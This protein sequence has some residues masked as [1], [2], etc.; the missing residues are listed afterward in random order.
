[1]SNCSLNN[2][3]LDQIGI[4]SLLA[5]EIRSWFLKILDVN[6]PVLKILNGASIGELI[7]IAIDTQAR[8][9]VIYASSDTTSPPMLASKSFILPAIGTSPL[10]N[11]SELE[12]FE[13]PTEESKRD[14]E[15]FKKSANLPA[16]S[17]PLPKVPVLHRS[18]KLSFSQAMFWFVMLF[19]EDKTGL[20]HT[21]CFRLTGKVRKEDFRLAV[22]NIGQRHEALRTCF[23][24]TGDQLMQGVMEFSVLQLE[25]RRI[26]KETEVTHVLHDLENHVYDVKRGKTMRLL[27]L[28][29]SPT[30]H[31][32]LIGA[33]SLVVDGVLFQVLLKDM[34]RYYDNQALES[35]VLQFPYFS[36]RQHEDF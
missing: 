1:M 27:L 3:R 4:D 36:Q 22:R 13:M 18:A 33:H 29:L 5:V 20:N 25:H 31:F 23:L 15:S 8:G 10:P 28:S 2:L 14:H 16:H 32:F 11:M 9:L 21:G 26:T 30:V 34:L 17:L 12:N 24:T 6:I 7:D 19:L 35:S